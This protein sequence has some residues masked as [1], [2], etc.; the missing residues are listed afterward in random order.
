MKYILPTILIIAS[1]GLFFLFINPTYVE[2]KDLKVKVD[3][4]NE[5]LNNSKKLQSVRDVL[6]SKYNGFAP[7]DI[8]RLG[9]LLPDNVDNIKLVLEIQKVSAQF[10]MNVENIK[11]DTLKQDTTGTNTANTFAAAAAPGPKKDYG[12]FNL[13]FSVKGSYSNFVGFLDSLEK[14]LRIVDIQSLSFSSADVSTQTGAA[15]ATPK[16]FYKYDFK[17]K[18]YWLK[19]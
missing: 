18:T 15:G 14:S 6:V 17:I 9:K 10:N 5:A 13:E 8:D 11:Y 3:S 7:D 2:V 12:D 19:G 1:L 4:Y 16:D